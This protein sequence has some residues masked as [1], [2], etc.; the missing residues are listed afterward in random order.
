MALILLAISLFIVL[1]SKSAGKRTAR[2]QKNF[3]KRTKN[4]P[5]NVGNVFNGLE[6]IK[7][8]SIESKFLESA[9][10]VIDDVERP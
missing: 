9:E 6:I 3:R 8:N 4:D 10:R 5:L 1:I 7:L 2:L